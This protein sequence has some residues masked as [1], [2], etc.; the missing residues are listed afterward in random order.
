MNKIALIVRKELYRVF[1]DKKMI[2][3][4]YVIPVIVTVAI[5]VLIGKMT[6][7]MTNDIEQHTSLV[8]IANATDDFKDAV[9]NSGFSL[10]QKKN[11]PNQRQEP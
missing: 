11:P 3:G 4:L 10:K 7:V 6:S 5:Y 2:M 9:E 1:G 8:T